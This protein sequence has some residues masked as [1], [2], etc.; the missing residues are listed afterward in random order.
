MEACRSGD[1]IPGVGDWSLS[2]EKERTA[3]LY[4]NGH[5]HL[6]VRLKG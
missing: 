2:S 6:R 4:I 5:P 1:A 3:A